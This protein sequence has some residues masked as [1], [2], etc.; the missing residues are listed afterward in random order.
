MASTKN[1]I[2]KKSVAP[3]TEMVK[4]YELMMHE[5]EDYYNKKLELL[6]LKHDLDVKWSAYN[7][8]IFASRTEQNF[9]SACADLQS[10]RE[11][12]IASINNKINS[13]LGG[14]VSVT[15]ESYSYDGKE[16][17]EDEIV[18]QMKRLLNAVNLS[19]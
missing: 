19:K 4:D 7:N 17:S 5:Y 14:D 3:Q 10:Q 2:K 1:S 11:K 9:Q 18:K 15:L 16:P 6:K 13:E 8:T 12:K